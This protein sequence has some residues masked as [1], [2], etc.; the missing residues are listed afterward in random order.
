MDKFSKVHVAIL[1]KLSR[2][3]SALLH[4]SCSI[5]LACCM[6]QQPLCK[7][8]AAHLAPRA[9]QRLAPVLTK[10]LLKCCSVELGRRPGRFLSKQGR[11]LVQLREYQK[12]LECRLHHRLSKFDRSVFL[13]LKPI[14]YSFD[15]Y[16]AWFFLSKN[17]WS[18]LDHDLMASI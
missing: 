15:V 4:S 1:H 17:Y 7:G 12:D 18:L 9:R 16:V 6:Q 10:A 13:I 5:Q 11:L 14:S 2:Q 8:G 3:L